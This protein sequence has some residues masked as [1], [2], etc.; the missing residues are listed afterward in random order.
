MSYH[1]IIDTETVFEHL[2]NPDWRIIDC[3]FDLSETEAGRE[4]YREAHLPGAL[5]AHLDEDL[6][7]KPGESSGRH[8]LPDRDQLSECFSR[9]GIDAQTQVVCYDQQ[10]SALAARLWF[11]LRWLGHD[12]VA[13]M[14]G[15]INKWQN[16]KRLTSRETPPV[17]RR[18]FIAAPSL[19]GITET[20]ELLEQLED[21]LCLID[22]RS[23]ERFC[24]EHE[25][26][27]PVA[28][29][30]PG[31]VNLPYQKN[32]DASG[33]FMP[34]EALRV[35][36]QRLITDNSVHDCVV[37]CGSGVTA[38]HTLLALELAGYSGATLYAGSWSEWI[39]DGNRPVE[40]GD[41]H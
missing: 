8:P 7:S 21:K 5:Y 26:I 33:C 37:M 12:R 40:I 14:D 36:Y 13:V 23:E 39:R 18:E 31:A 35:M 41:A 6:S 16:E 27:D 2:G 19:N 34:P 30:I 15:G 10:D 1:T 29:H 24:G 11:L 3:R 38:C 20:A 22:V 25:P 28:G 32:L 17:E 4:A 9:W